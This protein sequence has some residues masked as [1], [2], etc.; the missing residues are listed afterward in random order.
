VSDG[1]KV[2]SPVAVIALRARGLGKY[3]GP[4]VETDGA[5]KPRE[6]LRALLQMAGLSIATAA[7]DDVQRTVA[8]AGHVLRDVSFDVAA[9]SVVCIAG[10]SGSGKS[11][12][13]QILAGVLAPDAG[14]VEI[15]APVTPLLSV[16]DNLNA[17]LT[18]RE[19]IDA[20][21]QLEDAP[22]ED[23]AQYAADVLDFAELHGFEDAPLRTYST[24]MVMRLSVALALCGRPS[25]VLIDDVLGV[26]DIGFQQ[27][28]IDR[29]HA[30]KDAGCTLLLAFS[31]EALVRQL[32]TRVITLAGGQIASDLPPHHWTTSRRSSA[33]QMTWR[34]SQSLPENAVMAL[35][36]VAVAA[37]RDDA[38]GGL[39]L[40]IAFEGLAGGIRCRP[41]VVVARGE[42]PLFRSVYPEFVTIERPG[43]VTFAMRVPTAML[44]DG[45]YVVAVSAAVLTAGGVFALKSNETVAL[46]I[47]RDAAG[48]PGGP[49]SGPLLEVDFPWEVERVAVASPA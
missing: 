38:D 15:Y 48:G 23:A 5:A 39:D 35:R 46:E 41:V 11:V 25:I 42:A 28:C 32:A 47:R 43:P 33:A 29:V 1:P 2:S 21:P 12:L 36:S 40:T 34:V 19:N 45:D 49:G 20:S 9:G 22:A 24:G 17:R 10:P 26:G 14:A 30:L 37:A 13:L 7:P 16:G 31:D 27:K 8:A 3:F 44:P 4:T 6:A 18:A